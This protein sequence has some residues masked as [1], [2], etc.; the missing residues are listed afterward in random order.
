[1]SPAS[2]HGPRAAERDSAGTDI[3]VVGIACRYPGARGPEEYWRL[4]RDGRR[5][6]RELTREELAEGGAGRERIAD[7]ALVPVAGVLWDAECFDAAFFGYPAREAALIDPQQRIFLEEAW[8][9]MEDAGHTPDRFAGTVGVYAGQTLG[10][11]RERSHRTFLGTS[12]DLLMAADDKDFLPTRVSYKLGLTGPSIAVQTACS[13][14]LVAI[15]LACRALITHDCDMALAGGVSWTPLRRQGYLH[16]EGGVWSAD[17]QVRSFDRD[18]SGFVP[19]D[20][21]GIVV[22]RRLA[23]ALADGDR[24]YAVVKGSAV[25]NDGS[26]KLSY[27]APGVRGQQAVVEAALAVSAIGPDTVSYVEAHGTATAIGDAVEVAALTRAYRATAAAGRGYC[28][29]GSVKSNIGHTDAAAGVAGLIKVALMLYHGRIPPSPLM[30]LRPNPEIDF[31]TSPFRPATEAEDWPE[32]GAPRRGA[33]SSFGIGGTNAHVILEQPPPRPAGPPARP[34]QLMA[35]SARDEAALAEMARSCADALQDASDAELAD[36]AYTL[37]DGRRRF[38]HRYAGVFRDRSHAVAALRERAA[39]APFSRAWAA[40]GDVVFMFPGGGTQYPSMG[41][42]L[43]HDEPVFRAAVDECLGLLP[44]RTTAGRLHALW[45]VHGEKSTAE[46]TDP[47]LALP[48]VFVMEIALNRLVESFG[49]RPALLIGHSL[50][51]YAAACVAGVVSLRDALAIVVKRGELLSRLRDG[52]MLSVSAPAQEIEPFLD[53]EVCLSAVNGPNI[54]VLAGLSARIAEVHRSLDR[55][56]IVCRLLP[57]G[58]AA[59]SPLVDPV[60]GEFRAFLDGIELRAPSVPVV[61]NVTGDDKADLSDPEYWVAHLR[62]TVRFDAGLGHVL[63]QGPK[64]LVE[65]GPGTTLTTLAG[66][67]AGQDFVVVNTT[68]HPLDE[69]PDREVLLRALARLWEAGVE[70]DLPALWPR[71]RRRHPAVPYPFTPTLHLPG[72]ARATEPAPAERSPEGL[73]GVTWKRAVETRPAVLEATVEETGWV[74][75]SDSSPL[76]DAITAVLEKRGAPVAVVTPGREFRRGSSP[77]VTA[78]PRRPEHCEIDPRRPEHYERLLKTARPGPG[79]PLRIICLWGAALPAD[80]CP[81]LSE[82]TG[83]AHALGGRLG[84]TDLCLVTRG[85]LEITGAE[86][87]DPRA[88]LTIGAAGPLRC[89][90][91]DVPVRLVDVDA[92]DSA[93]QRWRAGQILGEFSRPPRQD[94]VGLRGGHR[95]LRGFDPLE[96]PPGTVPSLRPGGT[97]VITGGMSGI[98]LRLAGHLARAHSARLALVGRGTRGTP[99]ADGP[100]VD[101]ET[102]LAGREGDILLRHA[103]V[104]DP[105]ALGEVLEEVRSRFGA[106]HGVIHAAGVPGGG[107]AQF[108]DRESIDAALRAKTTGTAALLSALAET[109]THPDFIMLC[110]SLAAFSGAPGLACYGAANAFLDTFALRARRDGTPVLSVN[111][112]RWNGVGMAREVERHHRELT[113]EALSGGLSPDEGIAAFERCLTAVCLGQVVVSARPPGAAHVP[114]PV[115]A[116]PRPGR[117]SALTGPAAD[118][119]GGSGETGGWSPRELE[120]LAV[121]QEVLGAGAIGRH[122]DFFSLGGHSLSA[123]QVV[124]RCRERLGVRLSVKA[125]FGAPTIEGLAKELAEAPAAGE[126]EPGGRRLLMDLEGSDDS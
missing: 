66:A 9:A 13:T 18:A 46:E 71:P 96:T 31:E 52:A 91:T 8:H 61:S 101:G 82:V 112:D 1:M 41:R 97:Y 116:A 113:G 17:G 77:R 67:Q 47:S 98:G 95:W 51:E 86:R 55:Q 65:V 2:T 64:V 74:L 99:P 83:L 106:I 79:G 24:I 109:D 81:P 85:A 7:P 11:H 25:N 100:G 38:S 78:V 102:L 94:P 122:D 126:E 44:D 22:L 15:H 114:D 43:Y 6:I 123:L 73:Y 32:T 12:A 75:F 20:G 54:C 62:R 53:A 39:G 111:W 93:D 23:D 105:A 124:Q 45:A 69:R 56:G 10:T 68:R 89:E 92:D 84:R 104:A 37:A 28:R 4:I 117:S 59:H 26:D 70:V 58:T 40:R 36:L 33:V 29:V 19:A 14:S 49:V 42:E 118:G 57:L 108:L 21:L 90:L 72:P 125:L 50:G 121:W 80:V 110:S 30:P 16:Q 3:A 60:L 120:L 115:S 119:T 5:G 88:A 48:A 27:A 34:W 76:A 107:M 35:L 63:A 87:L 103:D